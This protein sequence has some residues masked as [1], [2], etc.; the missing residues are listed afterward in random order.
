[1]EC[2]SL[3]ASLYTS[4]QGCRQSILSWQS[5]SPTSMCPVHQCL[6]S[7]ESKCSSDSLSFPRK[8]PVSTCWISNC[9][10]KMIQTNLPAPSK[11]SP[12]WFRPQPYSVGTSKQDTLFFRS[13]VSD[14]FRFIEGGP[15]RLWLGR[16][17]LFLLHR[18]PG[19]Q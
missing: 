16:L 3:I 13:R 14:L 7:I 18:T 1:M 19:D 9:F 11:K 8:S 10:R 12:G 5:S 6:P 4:L 2:V 15:W 17:C